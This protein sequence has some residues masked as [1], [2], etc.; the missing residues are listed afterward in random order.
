[1]YTIHKLHPLASYIFL[2]AGYWSSPPTLNYM[3]FWQFGVV[4]T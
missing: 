2:V 4:H 3:P 1:M